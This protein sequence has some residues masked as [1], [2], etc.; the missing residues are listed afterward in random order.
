MSRVTAY[1]R[2]GSEAE[3]IAA[4]AQFRWEGDEGATWDTSRVDAGVPIIVTPAVIDEEGE[5]VT[6]AVM[7]DGYH[8]NLLLTA[9]DAALEGLPAWLG[10]HDTDS[11]VLIAGERPVTPQR[12]FA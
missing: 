6:P 7:R 12:V 3:A 2:F 1:F 4:L 9:R 10:T 11:R 8:V 5:E